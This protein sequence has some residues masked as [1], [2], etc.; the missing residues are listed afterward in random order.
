MSLTLTYLSAT[1]QKTGKADG[2][3]LLYVRVRVGRSFLAFLDLSLFVR[4]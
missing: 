2:V 4:Y 3:D 1:L